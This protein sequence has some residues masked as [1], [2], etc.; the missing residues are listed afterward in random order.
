MKKYFTINIF[1]A[2]LLSSFSTICPQTFDVLLKISQ[3]NKISFEYSYKEFDRYDYQNPYN[4]LQSFTGFQ[5]LIVDSVKNSNPDTIKYYLTINKVGKKT[6]KNFYEVISVKEVDTSFSE[7][8]YE[9]VNKDSAGGENQIS[10]WIFPYNLTEAVIDTLDEI[11]AYR[12]S[13][14]Y[15]FYNSVNDNSLFTLNDTL[16]IHLRPALVNYYDSYFVADYKISKDAGLNSYSKLYSF[17]GAGFIEVYKLTNISS[18]KDEFD[19]NIANEFNLE[20][21]YPN[22]FNPSTKIRY[23]IPAFVETHRD[24]SLQMVTIKV[25]DILGNEVSTLVN[26]LKTSGNYEVEFSA[27]QLSSGIYLYRLQAGNFTISRKMIL[28]K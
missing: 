16:I 3:Q 27:S 10:G 6:L 20:Q 9:I 21:N 7:I 8:I 2:F 13:N 5:H 11:P 28:L 26:E 14:F 23:S 1:V 17:F 4:V 25:Y 24:A 22:P 18:I 12:Y 15:R 19:N